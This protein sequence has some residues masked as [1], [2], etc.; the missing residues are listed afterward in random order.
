M[1]RSSPASGSP[2]GLKGY[3]RC[4]HEPRIPLGLNSTAYAN[5]DRGAQALQRVIG[6]MSDPQVRTLARL[7]EGLGPERQAF[8]HRVLSDARMG[9]KPSER[10]FDLMEH[11]FDVWCTRDRTTTI[12]LVAHI[13]A[14]AVN[15]RLLESILA[16]SASDP[17]V[18]GPPNP[19]GWRK[20]PVT[21]SA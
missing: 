16:S 21:E 11:L 20:V 4:C 2:Y 7:M 10:Y 18:S 12:V 13:G 9:R 17:P 5:I 14:L 15:D 1:R 19:S 3:R 8:I 6:H